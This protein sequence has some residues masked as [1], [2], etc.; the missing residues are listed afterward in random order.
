MKGKIL[1]Y[2]RKWEK[3]GYP[4][5]IPDEAPPE[6]EVLGKVPSYRLICRAILTNDRQLETLGYSRQKCEAY[7]AIKRAE[8]EAR[9]R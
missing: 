4:D 9:K 1:A 8:I 5:G 7:M 6:L 2:I 3:R